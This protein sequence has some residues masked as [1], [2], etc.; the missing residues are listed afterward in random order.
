[1]DFEIQFYDK[2]SGNVIASNIG[3]GTTLIEHYRSI[4]T[5]G[6]F[7]AFGAVVYGASIEDLF[8]IDEVT[9]KFT[10]NLKKYNVT[11]TILSKNFDLSNMKIDIHGLFAPKDTILK[12]QTQFLG[13]TV[14]EA[15][16][17][18]KFEQKLHLKSNVASEF[19]QISE[20]GLNALMRICDCEA[21]IPYW[22]VGIQDILLSKREKEEDFIPMSKINSFI[23][24]TNLDYEISEENYDEVYYGVK[25]NTQYNFGNSNN[26][27]AL[28]KGLLNNYLRKLRKPDVVIDGDFNAAFPYDLGTVMKNTDPS[29]KGI[30]Q[31]IVTSLVNNCTNQDFGYQ[32][33]YSYFKNLD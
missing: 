8:G 1:M 17:T 14:E 20:T 23:E 22:T 28:P 19:H 32:L 10:S 2:S 31:F 16:E 7:P 13:N 25:V 33:Q 5:I 26:Y 18:L 4:E 27:N 3:E 12:A 6:K 30:K 11:G 9:I 29:W 21:D 15:V 24:N